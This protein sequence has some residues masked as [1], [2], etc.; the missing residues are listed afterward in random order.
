MG[1]NNL[2]N[3]IRNKYFITVIVLIIVFD[4]LYTIFS[5]SP[6]SNDQFTV[7]PPGLFIRKRPNGILDADRVMKRCD[8]K[9][10]L[11]ENCLEY[12][13]KKED[14]YI[15]EPPSPIPQC[16]ENEPPM[17]FHV[18]WRGMIT[19]KLTLQMKSFLYTQPLECSKLYVWLQDSDT[20]IDLN[21]FAGKIYEKF[22]PKNIEFKKWDTKEQ[23][24]SDPLY[25]GWENIMSRHSSVSFSDLVRFVVLNRYG[26][27]YMDGDVLFLRDMR[28]L[29]HS[30]IDFSYK[31]SFKSEYNTAVLR[32]RANGTTSRK[33][34]SQAMLNKMNF[35]PF[36]IKNYLLAN[37]S[38]SLDTA[39]TK[40][41]YNSHLFM[42]SVPLFDPLWLKN[43]HRQNNNLRP[44]LRGMD[45]VWDP[46]F[47]PGEFP[48]IDN[49]NDYSPLDLRKAD[50][51]FRGAY[52]YHWHNNWAR[53]LIPTCWMGVINTAYDAFINGTQ[54]NIYGEFIQSY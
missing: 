20:D 11:V 45:D 26:G 7:P 32:L 54:R 35:H 31:W 15:I 48:N 28:P 16:N 34:I 10:S 37:T 49:L 12:L 29:Y 50:D 4:F 6:P 19:D 17:L 9:F 42:F 43:D 8:M 38:V 33:I 39:T 5:D 47:I 2:T 27:M 36:E 41:I 22:S 24:D 52:A 14:D 40:S 30:G 44:N 21:P 3:I 1:Q 53:E 18:F 23:L 51:F 25:K 46:K 13:D